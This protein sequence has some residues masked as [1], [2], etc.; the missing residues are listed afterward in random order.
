M[1]E[2]AVEVS[3]RSTLTFEVREPT[4]LAVQVA[5]TGGGQ[6]LTED[7]VLDGDAVHRE[8]AEPGNGWSNRGHHVDAA[9]GRLVIDYSATIQLPR[10]VRVEPSPAERLVA[11]RQSRYCPSDLIE[12]FAAHELGHLRGQPDASR[13]IGAWVNGRLG[14]ELGSSAPGDTAIDTLLLG[15]GVCRD[16]AH[17]TVMLCRALGVPA[18]FVAVYAPGLSPMD[19]HAVAEVAGADGWEI[20]DATRLAPRGSLV[21]IATGRDAADTALVTTIDGHAELIE[22]TVLA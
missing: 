20:V 19:F 22:S 5:A 12:G 2:S 7:L 9:A 13:Q 6:V 15:S 17:L 8:V 4:Q 16:Y 14:Y 18:R 11:L 1:P 10:A 3:V 21:R